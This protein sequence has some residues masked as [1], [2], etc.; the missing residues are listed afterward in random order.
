MWKLLSIGGSPAF[1]EKDDDDV[2]SI[3]TLILLF[4]RKLSNLFQI[5]GQFGKKI[6]VSNIVESL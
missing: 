2:P 4:A 5:L 1:V 3:I 6:V